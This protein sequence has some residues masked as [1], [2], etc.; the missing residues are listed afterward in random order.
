MALG[1]SCMLIDTKACRWDNILGRTTCVA[2]D[3][4]DL[5]MLIHF[6]ALRVALGPVASPME[7]M[8][9]APSIVSLP[10]IS[11]RDAPASGTIFA[12]VAPTNLMTPPLV[13][14][15]MGS[16][17]S[18][19]PTGVRQ[20]ENSGTAHSDTTGSVPLSPLSARAGT[21]ESAQTAPTTPGEPFSISTQSSIGMGLSILVVDDDPILRGLLQRLLTRLGCNVE[22]AENGQ[23]ALRKLGMTNSVEGRAS[24]SGP[25]QEPHLQSPL[26]ESN[27]S[28]ADRTFDGL[29]LFPSPFE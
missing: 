16:Y 5:G 11:E 22:G 26:V 1:I 19:Q 3:Q 18:A 13:S 23:V 4:L 2:S 15:P 28:S 14:S 17:T 25:E 24:G 12:H 6:L 10:M 21:G 9:V 20:G 27:A 7:G 29:L 8:L